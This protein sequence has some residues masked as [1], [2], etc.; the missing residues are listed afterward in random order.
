MTFLNN[1][2]GAILD[3]A[4]KALQKVSQLLT[5]RETQFWQSCFE[6]FQQMPGADSKFKH[7]AEAPDKEQLY[8]YLTEIK[9]ALVFAG[10][11]FQ[12]EAEPLGKN[13]PDLQISRDGHSAFVEVKRFRRMYPG[14]PNIPPSDEN[15]LD[16]TSFLEPY[17]NLERDIKKTKHRII[18][19]LE[20]VSRG[21]SIIAFWNDDKDLD[22]I[23]VEQAAYQLRDDS[24]Q[25]SLSLPNGLL[26]ILYASDWVLS[27]R[28]QQL[29]CFPLQTLETP[30]MN[31]ICELEKHSVDALVNR[32]L[33]G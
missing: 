2:R 18:E 24:A 22:D 5:E 28:G 23:E 19:K 26:F 10:L 6:R 8:D 11:G 12:V 27:G 16:D 9:Y 25:G 3:K 4:D 13:G 20:Q 17:G 1:G 21:T 32:A 31:W 7:I 15:F 29:Y 30:H 33:D 14:P